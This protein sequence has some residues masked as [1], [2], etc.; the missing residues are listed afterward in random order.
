MGLGP[1][2]SPLSRRVNHIPDTTLWIGNVG[3][4]WNLS[5]IYSEEISVLFDLA[6][7][8][9][10]PTLGRELIYCRFP[11]VDNQNNEVDVIEMAISALTMSLRKE[12]RTLVYCS[13]GASRSPVVASAALSLVKGEPVERVLAMIS[14]IASL[15]VS[16]GLWNQVRSLPLICES[17]LDK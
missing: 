4:V 6:L 14:T 2:A 11:L 9:P 13:N 15:D 8:E 3:D 10:I 7:N 16:P 17:T 1:P 12:K 5:R